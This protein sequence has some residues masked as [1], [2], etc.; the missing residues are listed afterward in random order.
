MR[1]TYDIESILGSRS[2]V[3]VLRVLV[4]VTIPLNAS[5]IAVHAGITRPAVATVLE[6]LAA[7]GIVRS[8]SAGKANVHQLIRENIY[9]ER[10]IG[11][12][13]S[14]EERI[15]DDLEL[16]LRQAFSSLAESGVLFGSYARGDQ[17]SDSDVDLILV[18]SDATNKT[19]LDEV[20][21]TYASGFRA[22]Y[23]AALSAMTYEVTEANTL[24]RTAPAFH[25]SLKRDG[26]VL[27][28]RGPWEWTDDG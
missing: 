11:P 22:R 1:P 6:N 27:W 7:M 15:P 12:L 4:N 3:A 19:A 21:F 28:G 9:T 26:L 25:E 23:G 18:A 8:S 10:L 13:F 5:Q 16:D 2:R 20:V 14:A 24:W 17:G